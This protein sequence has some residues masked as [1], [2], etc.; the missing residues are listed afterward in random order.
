MA[1]AADWM[2]AASFIRKDL[3]SPEFWLWGISPEGIGIIGMLLNFL[4]ASVVS[5]F[6]PQP[7]D[8]VQ[9]LVEDIRVP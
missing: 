3:D 4:V 5:A 9:A 1:T 6:T 2:S 8:D 7:P